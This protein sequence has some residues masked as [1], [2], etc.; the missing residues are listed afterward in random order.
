MPRWVGKDALRELASPKVRSRLAQARMHS[1]S[2]R[3]DVHK[4]YKLYIGG[5]FVRSESGRYVPA[6]SAAGVLLENVC[7]ASLR[8]LASNMFFRIPDESY[9]YLLFAGRRMLTALRRG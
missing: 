7:Q 6:Q 5:N 1:M 4:T 3:L 9:P 2:T 8:P